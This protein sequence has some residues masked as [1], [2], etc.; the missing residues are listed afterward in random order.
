[1][2]LFYLPNNILKTISLEVSRID[3]HH[4]CIVLKF[5]RYLDEGAVIDGG[6]G[7]KGY[8]GY[9]AVLHEDG[10][11]DGRNGGWRAVAQRGRQLL[12]VRLVVVVI[13]VVEV[14]VVVYD[15]VHWGLARARATAADSSIT[16]VLRRIALVALERRLLVRWRRWLGLSVLTGW[17]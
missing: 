16:C 2:Y 4:H 8:D 11:L 13:A 3:N 7:V 5:Y 17:L 12:Q 10:P 15:S 9:A 14:V 1:M 6:V